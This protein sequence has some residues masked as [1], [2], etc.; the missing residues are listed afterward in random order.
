MIM[1]LTIEYNTDI[2]NEPKIYDKPDINGTAIH[3]E[4]IEISND[5]NKK[6]QFEFKRQSFG[7]KTDNQS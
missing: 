5:K 2:D 6:L 7:G 4:E 1:A 3:K